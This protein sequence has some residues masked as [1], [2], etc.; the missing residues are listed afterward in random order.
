MKARHSAFTLLELMIV[1][2][3]IC[4]LAGFLFAA[5]AKAKE[6]ATKQRC[7]AI[8]QLLAVASENYYKEYH[9]YP[10]PDPD[11]VGAG[12]TTLG[13]NAAFRAAYY[14]GGAWTTDG[15]N[16]ALVWMLSGRRNPE[17]FLEL[18]QKWFVKIPEAITGP[19]GRTLYKC[20]DGF[21]NT[22]NIERPWQSQSTYANTYMRITSAGADGKLGVIGSSTDKDAKDNIEQ[23]LKR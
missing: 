16:I 7:A 13:A 21:G 10:Y 15:F 4:V 20:Q 12:T 3:I 5:A 2:S 9:D 6:A 1:I 22:I 11:F 17:P 19:D 14:K 18:N 23:Y 8:V